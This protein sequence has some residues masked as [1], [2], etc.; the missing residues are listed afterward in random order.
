MHLVLVLAVHL[1]S[2][3]VAIMFRRDHPLYLPDSVP[4]NN[5]ETTWKQPDSQTVGTDTDR[6]V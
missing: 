1:V 3:I 2:W 4:G 6:E 5:L